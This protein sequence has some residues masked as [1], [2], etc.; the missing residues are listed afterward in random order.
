M[1]ELTDTGFP[2]G[3]DSKE[4]T[5]DKRDVSLIPGSGRSPGEGNGYPLQCPCLENP[6]ERG[7]WRAAVS[8]WGREE[9]DTPKQLNSS[10]SG[11]VTEVALLAATAAKSLQSCPTL[12]D[13][14]DSSPPGSSVHRILQARTLEWVAFPSPSW[15]LWETE[16]VQLSPFPITWP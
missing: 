12:C 5:C 7:A 10:S 3:S 11:L 16:L 2:C 13:P 4:S 8:P 15:H 6:M 14:M 1:P 9:W